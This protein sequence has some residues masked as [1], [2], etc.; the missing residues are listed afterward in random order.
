MNLIVLE[1]WE[2]LLDVVVGLLELHAREA[3]T[4]LHA[5]EMLPLDVTTKGWM[6]HWKLSRHRVTA[7]RAVRKTKLSKL[8]RTRLTSKV[9]SGIA[10]TAEIAR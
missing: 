7:S 1:H 3:S 5:Q 9:K 2:M 10:V 4:G 8:G 6:T